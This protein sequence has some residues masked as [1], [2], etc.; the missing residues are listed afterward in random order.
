MVEQ[1]QIAKRGSKDDPD[2]A[3]L[4]RQL[5]DCLR[6]PVPDGIPC[7]PAAAIE[8]IVKAFDALSPYDRDRVPHL[9]KV[10]HADRPDVR[11]FAV[12]AK[13]YVLYR[14]RL[15]RRIEIVKASESAL[16]AIIGR[17]RNESTKAGAP[18]LACLMSTWT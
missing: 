9:L 1:R 15:G 5:R 18:H 17:S 16:G 3:C 12:S 2:L 8:E 10:E 7:L 11:W 13:R 4:E 6:R 14:W